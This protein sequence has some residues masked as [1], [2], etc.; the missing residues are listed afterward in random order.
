MTGASRPAGASG[1]AAL[2]YAQWNPEMLPTVRLLELVFSF[3]FGGIVGSFLNAC[4]WRIPRDIS[5]VS[6]TRSFCP[7]CEAQIAWYDNIPILSY[8]A[9]R[10]RCRSCK[11]PIALRYLWVEL[12]TAF[13]FA[14]VVYHCRHLNAWGWGHT[15][16]T[17]CIFAAIV[18]VAFIDLDHRIIPNEVTIP[19]IVLAPILSVLF[20]TLH[21]FAPDL[22]AG[23]RADALVSSLMGIVLGG[24]H[25][26]LLGLFGKALF[27]KEAMGFGDVKLM[28]MVGGLLGW[29]P[30]VMATPV[31]ACFG[32][33]I[34]I[35]IV[36]KTKDHYLPFGPFLAIGT[37]LMIFYGALVF[38]YFEW[39]LSGMTAAFR[40][41]MPLV[42]WE[43][44]G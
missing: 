23:D 19:G 31:A 24:G 26:W 41:E 33:V 2:P 43:G 37:V 22:F 1:G 10:G 7:K 21:Q 13:G 6:R 8:L 25:I 30:A 11:Q 14:L 27:G 34:G 9:L 16:T 40:F 32:S 28:A 4:I 42:P 39:T 20:P 12:I 18:L 3:A 44:L 15:A 5:I 35:V 17:A 38:A 29:F 36:L